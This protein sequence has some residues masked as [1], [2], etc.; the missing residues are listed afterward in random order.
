MTDDIPGVRIPNGSFPG[1]VTVLPGAKQHAEMLARE[2]ELAAA[3]G[4]VRL[5]H[6]LH[7]SPAEVCGPD[8]SK[9]DEFDIADLPI[10]RL[11]RSTRSPA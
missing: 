8:G 9:K 6:A 3:G 4:A 11:V 1:V 5:P 7:A 2:A 10:T